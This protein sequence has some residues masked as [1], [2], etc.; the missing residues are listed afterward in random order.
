[1]KKTILRTI[2][3]L[4]FRRWSRKG[5]A[6]FCSMGR[7]VSI[8][9]LKKSIADASLGKQ[10]LTSLHP[11]TC[12]AGNQ[13]SDT[14]D[15]NGGGPAIPPDLPEKELH[16]LPILAVCLHEP[17]A[18]VSPVCIPPLLTRLLVG[19]SVRMG[20]ARRALSIPPPIIS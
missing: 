8:G 19:T 1:M 5:Y 13:P 18:A 11:N 9:R 16:T 12:A 4:R 20:T 15:D 3:T 6:A 7:V 14:A 10:G 2:R 17:P